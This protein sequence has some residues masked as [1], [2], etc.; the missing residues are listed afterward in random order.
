MLKPIL[1]FSFFTILLSSCGTNFS[2]KKNRIAQ[3]PIH[4]GGVFRM[5]EVEDFTSLYP[6]SITEETGYQVACQIF[7]GLL[8]PDSKDLS[9]R[10]C[11]ATTYEIDPSGTHYLFHLRKGVYFQDDACFPFSQGREVQASDFKWCF[12]KLCE[13]NA[14]NFMFDLTFRDR[15]MGANE[16]YKSTADNH[17]L[18]GGVSGIKVIDKRT[19]EITLT[20]PFSSFLYILTMPGTWIYPKEAYEM[21]KNDLSGHCV[22]TGPFMITRIKRQEFAILGRNENYWETDAYGNSLPYMDALHFTFMKDKK[23]EFLKFRTKELD[24]IFRIPVELIPS[25]MGEL[26]DAK[27]GGADFRMQSV[28]G[29]RITYYGFQN[30]TPPFDNMKV[31]QAFNYAINRRDIV[32]FIL[33]GE[34]IPGEYGVVPPAFTNYDTAGFRG[35]S[36]DPDKAR[37]L[38]SDAGFPDGKGFPSLTLEINGGSSD[39]NKIMADIVTKMLKENLNVDVKIDQLPAAQNLQELNETART[40]I[41]YSNWTA[42]YPDPETFLTMF[43]SKHIPAKLSDPS[44]I[45][46][47]RYRNPVFDS[48]F[49]MAMKETDPKK[50][51]DLCREA[52]QKVTYDAA[53]M[54]VFYDELDRLVQKNIKNFDANA[55]EYRQ[56]SKVWIAPS[57]KDK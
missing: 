17:P 50:K 45:N 46:V 53:I 23:A 36:F 13:K 29:L 6:L 51:A 16:Y 24:M 48:L 37:K 28:P 15:V 41:F 42:D 30:M 19:L 56:L 20:Q 39:R 9:I 7:E 21:Y 33:Q 47:V 1:F 4:L 12:D 11:L 25:I 35:Y 26:K 22:G 44:I 8:R 38:L 43:Y 18:S 2:S 57:G 32:K 31:R 5:N 3:G 54:P 55:L 14:G 34:G 27:P 49:L 10:P 40:Q 52:D